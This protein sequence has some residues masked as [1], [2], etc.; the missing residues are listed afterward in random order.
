MLNT[1][2][3]KNLKDYFL[4]HLPFL[5]LLNIGLLYK[6]YWYPIYKT[7]RNVNTY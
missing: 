1:R 2:F 3:K 7:K 4:R 6:S 5:D